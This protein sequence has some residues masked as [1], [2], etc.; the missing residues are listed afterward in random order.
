M[1]DPENSTLGQYLTFLRQRE[2]QRR[3]RTGALPRTKKLSR[4]RAAGD[5]HITASYLTKVE[6]DEVGQVS[7]EIL[8]LLTDTYHAS[9]DE[10]RYLCDLAGHA[11]PYPALPGL[12]ETL[13]MPPMTEFENALSSFM[14]T[15]MDESTS[16][17]V[18]FYTPQRRLIAANAAYFET[19]P[20][21][22]P[23]MY[24]LE[25]SFTDEAK[26]VMLNWDDQVDQG[27]AWHRGIIG[28]YGHT[29]WAQ[30]SHRR[31]WQFDDFRKKWEA[32]EVSYARPLVSQALLA[33]RGGRYTMIMENW[34]LQYGLPIMRSRSRLQPIPN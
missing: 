27:V 15:E 28:R 6:R 21:H 31:L 8:R 30:E 10:W 24:M 12:N 14:R 13:D 17:L 25:W 33:V 34:L 22:R 9:D 3:H 4:E 29:N 26:T 19:F 23:G 5:A 11:A 2:E 7:V 1:G 16:D 32:H 18:S 20:T